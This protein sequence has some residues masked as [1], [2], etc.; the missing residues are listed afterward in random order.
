MVVLYFTKP[1]P[2]SGDMCVSPAKWNG[3]T[4]TC[5]SSPGGGGGA[6]CHVGSTDE[7]ASCAGANDPD[8][9]LCS[10]ACPDCK[11][12]CQGN[13]LR[14]DATSSECTTGGDW[15]S[16]SCP[17]SCELGNTC[18]VGF[19][20]AQTGGSTDARISDTITCHTSWANFP[21]AGSASHRCSSSGWTASKD[22]WN[23][24][25]KGSSSCPNI[26]KPTANF[27]Y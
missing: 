27:E 10:C 11:Q 18:P 16:T 19:Y 15:S 13:G 6:A 20:V 12:S 1:K 5:P 8:P 22:G 14:W 7:I 3:K 9:G 25:P 26:S 17:K 21:T 4:C 23:C 2:C 24:C